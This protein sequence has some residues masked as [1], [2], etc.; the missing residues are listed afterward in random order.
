MRFFY[1]DNSMVGLGPSFIVI[2]VVWALGLC[3]GIVGAAIVA[4]RIALP[5]E[6]FVAATRRMESGEALAPPPDEKEL[7]QLGALGG[8]A[9]TIRERERR[10]REAAARDPLTG[11]LN[12]NALITVM[13]E[14]LGER[15]AA[16]MVV[17]LTRLQETLHTVGR[18]IA[19]RMM[20]EAAGRLRMLVGDAPLARVGD[21]TFATWVNK[22]EGEHALNLASRIVLAFE[23][24]YQ[25][26]YLALDV[27]AAVG[28][29][30]YP[31]HGDQ[32]SLLLQ[33]A[34][35]AL[36]TGRRMPDRTAVYN[37][38]TDPRHPEHL[39]LMVDLRQALDRNELELYYQPK[40]DLKT[41]RISGVE[42]L[43]RWHH[44]HRGNVRPDLFIG[45]AEETGNIPRLTRWAL[46][47]GIAQAA[48]WLNRGL[49]IRVS[50]NVSVYDL[51]DADLATRI[52]RLLIAHDVPPEYLMLEVTES[53]I[54]GEPDSAIAVLRRIADLGIQLS[55]DDFGVGYSS[56]AYLSRL[57]VTELKI[58]KSFIQTLAV[59]SENQ[60]IVQSVIELGHRLG[61]TVIAEGV[62]DAD[63]LMGL[64]VLG[65]D[66][67]QGYYIAKPL[68]RNA[69][70][71][72]FT[73]APWPTRRLA[74]A[75]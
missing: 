43:V 7:V 36:L 58:D 3:G 31:D 27:T 70:E 67:A 41:D 51:A 33:H 47:T 26:T 57:P 8:L 20:L 54:M 19:D 11:L 48:R 74:T 75:S 22:L 49:A 59:S 38:A 68:S 66:Y 56:L 69:M 61:Y 40:L 42:A 71:R 39:S 16:V 55:I 73:D 45:L 24:P 6:Q 18:E 44:E 62:E 32:A 46:T 9:I 12:R 60:K 25:E 52:S 53:A 50:V 13:G 30:L 2:G 37:P 35:V 72:F 23:R 14:Q 34:D 65:C 21:D 5:I 10:L 29:A 63:A 1:T 64:K 28:I 15:N 4:R 17:G